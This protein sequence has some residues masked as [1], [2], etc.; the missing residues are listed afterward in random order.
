MSASSRVFIFLISAAFIAC[1]I[2][3]MTEM[4]NPTPKPTQLIPEKTFVKLLYEMTRIETARGGKSMIDS[5][6]IQVYYET[7]FDDFD[8]NSSQ[9]ESSFKYYHSNPEQMAKYYQW[10][11]DS[12]RVD[13][14][15][16]RGPQH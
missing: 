8:V 11:I 10:V 14:N 7:L 3:G 16:T 6:P 4:E 9:V 2:G 13:E 12:L 15:E 1:E 5:I